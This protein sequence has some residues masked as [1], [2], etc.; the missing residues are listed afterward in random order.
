AH[1]DWKRPIHFTQVFILQSLG[2]LDYLQFDGYS[3]RLV[4]IY[5]PVTS[6][7]EIGRLDP[8][9]VVPLLTET[10]RY[11][12]LNDPRVYVDDFIQTNL[13]AAHAR[14]TFARTAKELLVRGDTTQAVRL[15]DMGLEKL[16]V[17]QIRYSESNTM[18][19]IECYYYAGETDKGDA[20]LLDYADNLMQYIDH[21]LRFEGI[22]GDMVTDTIIGKMQSLE[23]LYYLAVCAGRNEA[24]ARLND[25]YRTLGAL[26]E[27]L[28]HPDWSTST[29][30]VRL[31]EAASQR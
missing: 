27:E 10:F 23:R 29:D 30:S 21:Y 5:T 4:P 1:F 16:P 26:E 15:L 18:P 2:L 8:E 7:R 14:E 19:F 25:Y 31:P 17:R 13:S 28:I 12:N 6:V 3:Y 24:V 11:G 20:L 9:V 22:K